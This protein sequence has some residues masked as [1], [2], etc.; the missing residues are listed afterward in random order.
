[1]SDVAVMRWFLRLSLVGLALLIAACSSDQVRPPPAELRDFEPRVSLDRLW[2]R[3]VGVGSD[4]LLLDLR[5]A[6]AGDSLYLID[7]RGRITQV[8]AETGRVLQTFDTD[9]DVSAGLAVDSATLYFIDERGLLVALARD[10]GLPVWEAALSSESV[11]RPTIAADNVIVQTVDGRI[12]AFGR[13]DGQKRWEYLSGN[14]PALSLR[15]NAIP[16]V[17][18]DNVL[19]GLSGGTVISLSLRSG[20]PQWEARIAIPRGKTELERLV[21]VDSALVLDR[22]R[23]YALSYQGRLVEID[24]FDGRILWAVDASSYL[25]MALDDRYIYLS[26]PESDL[27][28]Y[29][30]SGGVEVWRTNELSWRFIGAPVLWQEVLAVSD[31]EGY[32]HLLSREDGSMVGRIRPGDEAGIRVPPLVVGESLGVYDNGGDISTWQLRKREVARQ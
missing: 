26:T 20:E 23:L 1:M 32:V 21:D 24:P 25:D 9:R 29:A 2:S 7:A 10:S 12:S 8:Q 5:P 27:V 11:V 16:V 17:F 18:G 19:V 4:E 15:G 30:R 6:L 22:G 31:L 14:Q 13:G 3:D 28:A